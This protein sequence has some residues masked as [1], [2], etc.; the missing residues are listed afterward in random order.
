[1]TS[2]PIAV[3]IDFS[4]G[5]RAALLEAMRMA[6]FRQ[7]PVHAVHVIDT[8][9]SVDLAQ[10]AAAFSPD[11]HRELID[12]AHAQWRR[13]RDGIP[14]ALDISF[15]VRLDHR[16]TGVVSF[17]R[18]HGAGVLVIG[19]FGD[20]RPDVG[21]GTVAT[22]CVRHAAMD[23][24]VV[25]D[26][27]ASSFR[28]VAACI[29]FSRSS[30][31]VMERAVSMAS[32]DNA[33]LHVVHVWDAMW[34]GLST[35]SGMDGGTAATFQLI[36]EQL[37][38]AAQQR[39][40]DFSQSEKA[41]LEYLKPKFHLHEQSGHRSGIV[42]FAQTVGA[43]LLVLGRRGRSS[44]PDLLL[45]STAEKALRETECSTLVVANPESVK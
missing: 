11:L 12:G 3:G 27:Q 21:F 42:S 10:A 38:E 45:G 14:G 6:A 13:F 32:Q 36:R 26:T 30:R 33:A 5:C 34:A 25:R 31:A 16:G 7:V 4:H 29:D 24:L 35:T 37:R 2:K 40:V 1:M 28:C 9:L 17:A 41:A 8:L 15:D 22:T 39:L 44:V 20:K 43:D 18:D 23:V 19:A